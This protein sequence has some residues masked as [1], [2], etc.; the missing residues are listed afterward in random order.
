MASITIK[1]IDESGEPIKNAEIGLGFEQGYRNNAPFMQAVTGNSDNKGM[2]K[3]RA[4]TSNLVTYGAKKDGYYTSN[5]IHRFKSNNGNRWEPWNPELIVVL[6]K[7]EKPVPM[8]AR[9]ITDLMLPVLN[10]FI[11]FDLILSDWVKPYG[12]GVKAD[13][14]F[15]V[16]SNYKNDREFDGKLIVT[17]PGS[18]GGF[19]LVKEQQLYGSHY[20]LPRTA[21]SEG[22]LKEVKIEKSRKPNMPLISSRSID[23]NY[24]FMVTSERK[25]VL[26]KPLYGKIREDFEFFFDAEKASVNFTYY[27]NPDHTKNLEFDSKQNLYSNLPMQEQVRFP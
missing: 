7:I 16:V 5:Y 8:Y 14:N 13:I 2:F 9:K 15:K 26:N 4:R 20:K 24:I 11:G 6:R 1:V 18:Q 21:P 27:L 12:R 3:A 23:N 17:V 10:Q 25:D 22:Y 19:V